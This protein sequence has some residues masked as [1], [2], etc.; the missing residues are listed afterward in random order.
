VPAAKPIFWD[1]ITAMSIDDAC[2]ILG[3]GPT[4]ATE[5]FQAKTTTR[6]TT[7][8]WP[9]VAQVMNEVGV[10][11]QYQALVGPFKPSPLPRAQPLTSTV[12]W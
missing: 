10:T 3:G 4:P 6:L 11:R 12:T 8:F 5:Y 7:A 2:Q 9:I 1:T